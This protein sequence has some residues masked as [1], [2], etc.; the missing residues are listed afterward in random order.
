MR[1]ES[2]VTAL[3]A[4][5]GITIAIGAIAFLILLSQFSQGGVFSS[6]KLSGVE[7]VIALGVGFYH[8][9]FGILCFGVAQA[10]FE[11][12]RAAEMNSTRQE[13]RSGDQNPAVTEC[14]KCDRLY[15]GDLRGQF[16]ES[17]GGQL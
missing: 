15:D 10:V 6:A 17:C 1:N 16:C 11:G 12:T 3:R 2:L 8:V 13:S 5:G 14:P 4:T 7:F 9:T